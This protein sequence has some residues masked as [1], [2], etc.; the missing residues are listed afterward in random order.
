MRDITLPSLQISMTDE[1][2]A[3][4]KK[5]FTA[6]QEARANRV[7]AIRAT[8]AKATLDREQL[9]DR[10]AEMVYRDEEHRAFRA[11]QRQERA[12]SDRYLPAMLQVK[13]GPPVEVILK[14]AANKNPPDATD[15]SWEP[16]YT[17]EAANARRARAI[18]T[19]GG[20]GR[21]AKFKRLEDETIRLYLAKKWTSVPDAAL[22]ITP[23]IVA[24][25]KKGNGD[26]ANTTT[27]PLEWIRAYKKAKKK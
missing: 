2:A 18:S 26:L 5:D 6:S 27:K 1:Q 7:T 13:V 15:D 20:E 16:Y 19:K 8:I 21:A 24:M 25:S 22:E 9:I 10:L 3:Q 12:N 17:A 11:K 4:S 14:K 23:I